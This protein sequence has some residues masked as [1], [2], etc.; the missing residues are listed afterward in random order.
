M[1]Y[2]VL[3]TFPAS[4]ILTDQQ[5][6]LLCEPI[7]DRLVQ[8]HH[9]GWQQWNDL[10]TVCEK[11]KR[12]DLLATLS[13]T[14]RANFVNNHSVGKIVELVPSE[15]S[16]RIISVNKLVGVLV[17]G[18][19]QAAFVRLKA[20]NRNLKPENVRT[21]LQSSLGK[22]QWPE[23][24]FVEIDTP[25]VPTVIT[26]GY[27]LSHDESEIFGVYMCCHS[28]GQL[29]WSYRIDSSQAG[30]SGDTV[31]TLPIPDGDQPEAKVVVVS[32]LAADDVGEE[33]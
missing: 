14:T 11:D 5:A 28:F 13:S 17:T 25:A 18:Q 29:R 16:A 32:K 3:M 15:S 21:N 31:P 27:K 19:K 23:D 2:A 22:Q 33:E 10:R 7:H 30:G 6:Q 20:L 26:A 12:L 9:H 24:L 4:P 1:S 8:A